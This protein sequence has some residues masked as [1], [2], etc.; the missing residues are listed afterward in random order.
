M[1][2]DRI[3]SWDAFVISMFFLPFCSVLRFSHRMSVFYSSS[4]SVKHDIHASFLIRSVCLCLFLGMWPEG[5]KPS[6]SETMREWMSGPPLEQLTCAQHQKPPNRIQLTG[7]ATSK[8]LHDGIRSSQHCPKV[9]PAV[10]HYIQA[11][12]LLATA[13]RVKISLVGKLRTRVHQQPWGNGLNEILWGI[14]I[15]Y[16]AKSHWNRQNHKS[17]HHADQVT[18][19]HPKLELEEYLKF[20]FL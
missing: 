19:S 11:T 7:T 1:E 8:W 15:G 17:P 16:A 9:N 5:S 12:W 18:L 4:L 14:K 10:L 3:G 6:W 2:W 20:C 13:R